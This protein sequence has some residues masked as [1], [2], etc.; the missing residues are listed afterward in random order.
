MRRDHGSGLMNEPSATSVG[1]DLDAASR[2][3]EVEPQGEYRGRHLRCGGPALRQDHMGGEESFSEMLGEF[4][5]TGRLVGSVVQARSARLARVPP[6]HVALGSRVER[7]NGSQG[8]C[9][10]D[11]Q[12]GPLRRVPQRLSVLV[13]D[14]GERG[15]RSRPR[16]RSG[17]GGRGR[18]DPYQ[19]LRERY[20]SVARGPRRSAGRV[21]DAGGDGRMVLRQLDGGEGRE[22]GPGLAAVA[23][24]RQPQP[25]HR[26][27]HQDGARAPTEGCLRAGVPRD[28]H[29]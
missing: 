5:S 13:D 9:R 3:A 17:A 2:A 20:L 29:V 16:V 12:G 7:D 19:R 11:A 25:A 6:I 10:H 15:V 23:I 27:V 1:L 26:E 28:V 4:R 14:G 21:R 24:D 18:L 8:A 22:E